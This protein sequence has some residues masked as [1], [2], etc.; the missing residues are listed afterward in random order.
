M[1]FLTKTYLN[2]VWWEVKTGH[3]D[4]KQ[5]S[6]SL[7]IFGAFALTQVK[8]ISLVIVLKTSALFTKRCFYK[9]VFIRNFL[10]FKKRKGKENKQA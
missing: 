1:T 3:G 6:F 8:N 2:R 9:L 5:C 4:K 7:L 10:T